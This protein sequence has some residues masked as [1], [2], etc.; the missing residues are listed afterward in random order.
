M[1]TWRYVGC[2]NYNWL[3][4][5][6]DDIAWESNANAGEIEE[7]PHPNA[8]I[9]YGCISRDYNCDVIA[10][11]NNIGATR[12]TLADLRQRFNIW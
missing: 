12:E 6:G 8:E 5:N 9:D 7:F 10:W 4:T 11:L 1:A 2:N 3:W